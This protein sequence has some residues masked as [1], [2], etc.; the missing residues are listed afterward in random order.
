[1]TIWRRGREERAQSIGTSGP[2]LPIAAAGYQ[3]IDGGIPDVAMQSVAIGTVTDLIASLSSELPIK[4]YRG[5]GE[6]R[7]EL[8]VPAR[9]ADPSGDGYGRED[10]AYQ[11]VMSMLTRG[12]TFLRVIGSQ[13]GYLTQAEILNADTVSGTM[14]NGMPVWTVNGV[15]D[16]SQIIH[17]RA[18]P[19]A[20]QVKGLSPIAYKASQI[21][22]S[23]S[24]TQFGRQWF[25]DGGQPAGILSNEN[26][27]DPDVAKVAKQRFLN[28]IRG[29]R[30][31]VVMGN[32]WTWSNVQVT[33]EESQFLQT[34]EWSEAQCA[35][36]YGPGFAEL[37]GY[38]TSGGLTYS[39]ITDRDLHVLKYGLDR[40][41]KSL[42]RVLSRFL[43]APQYVE[44]NRDALLAT[45][46]M[47]RYLAHASAIGAGWKTPNEVRRLERLDDHEGGDDLKPIGGGSAVSADPAQNQNDNP[48]Q[49]GGPL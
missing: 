5:Q 35:R 12:N 25:T 13:V 4:V 41:L 14:N 10:W 36:I 29:K 48:S 28:A 43:P 19:T 16:G 33:P 26:E 32:G 37:L 2:W 30:E 21:G 40:W 15:A 9:L 8:P 47:Q 39:N 23:L 49:G 31:P 17:L 20:G 27:I 6:N 3:Y 44:I 1:M 7:V 18:Y 45:T 22:I 34:M 42:E 46:T 11:Y 38:G 24:A